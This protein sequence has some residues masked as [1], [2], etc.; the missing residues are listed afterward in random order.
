MSLKITSTNWPN[1]NCHCGD[2]IELH[3][4]SAANLTITCSRCHYGCFSRDGIYKSWTPHLKPCRDHDW[5]ATSNDM[6]TEIDHWQA[7]DNKIQEA[8]IS[9]NV[10]C[11][12]EDCEAINRVNLYAK[13]PMLDEVENET[14]MRDH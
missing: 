9:F 1:M 8:T 14:P 12:N 3:I 7:G 5:Q 11:A 10:Y 6:E 4:S 13:N 2:L